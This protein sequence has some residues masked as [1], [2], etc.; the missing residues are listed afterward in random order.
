MSDVF[1][2]YNLDIDELPEFYRKLN[3]KITFPDGMA[4]SLGIIYWG[5]EE[6]IA[7]LEGAVPLLEAEGIRRFDELLEAT[8]TPGRMSKFA[9]RTGISQD[10]LRILKHDI[11]LWFPKPVSL[12]ELEPF[13]KHP[14]YLEAFA[15]LGVENQLQ[16]ISSGQ[17]SPGR[18][19]LSRQ[20]DI[21]LE[22]IVEIVKY[23]DVYR[24][25]SNLS[26]IR[27]KIYY[28]MGLDTWQKW[29]NMTSEAI[30]AM[31]TDY[32]KQHNLEEVRLVPRPKE[33]RNG[34]EWAKHHLSI[35]EV[36]W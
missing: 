19:A 2:S 3:E 4:T 24:M 29:A 32:V 30:I 36:E 15:R 1:D 20:T 27:T 35:F 16:V 34:I 9:Q 8:R 7:A 25:G 13:Q 22:T 5:R 6:H 23:C 31:F 12:E 26:H 11:G 10:L 14:E 18:Q 17:T 28:D 21:S 33:V